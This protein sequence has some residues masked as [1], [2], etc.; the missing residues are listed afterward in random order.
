MSGSGDFCGT[1]EL[2][3]DITAPT[4][5]MH[6]ALSSYPSDEGVICCTLEGPLRRLSIIIVPRLEMHVRIRRPLPPFRVLG[7]TVG[8]YEYHTRMSERHSRSPR[9]AELR[10]VRHSFH[11]CKAGSRIGMDTILID[12][13]STQCG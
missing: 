4:N 6:I 2:V 5:A 12:L 3:N 13:T 9:R 10:R 11:S 7:N 1:S 8:T